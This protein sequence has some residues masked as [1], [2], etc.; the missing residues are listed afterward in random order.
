MESKAQ[1]V[2][3]EQLYDIMN[4]ILWKD[5]ESYNNLISSVNENLELNIDL[6]QENVF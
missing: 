5:Q 4:F 3:N 2:K 1:T 6:R